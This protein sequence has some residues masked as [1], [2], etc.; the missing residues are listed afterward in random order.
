[1]DNNEY[2]NIVFVHIIDNL[3]NG[4]AEQYLPNTGRTYVSQWLLTSIF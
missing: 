1:M 3:F 2:Y 4:R